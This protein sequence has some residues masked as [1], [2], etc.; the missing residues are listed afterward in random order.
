MPRLEKG[1]GMQIESER[2]RNNQTFASWFVR[3]LRESRATAIL[4]GVI[5]LGVVLSILSPVFLSAHNLQNIVVQSVYTA[6]IAVGMTFV[7][8]TAGID[9]SVGGIVFLTLVVATQISLTVKGPFGPYLVYMV[10]ILLGAVLGLCNG[11]I[12]NYLRIDPVITTLATLNIFRGLAIHISNAQILIPNQ[13]ARFL[14]VGQV[15]SFPVPI[16][17]LLIIAVLAALSLSYTKFGRYSLAIGS[18]RRSALESGLSV[19][20]ISVLVYVIGGFCAAIGGLILVGRVGAVQTDMGIG[21][22]FTVITAVVLGGTVLSGGKASIVGSI[23][24]AVFLVMIDN[25]LDLLNASVYIYDIVR[26]AVLVAAVV[27]DRVSTM[28]SLRPVRR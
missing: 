12:V 19:R 3:L 16:L 9:I 24:G 13:S 4:S 7:I 26:G 10:S 23:L 17:V 25:G 14:G 27:I 2:L 21:V 28:R 6:V 5:I 1:K 22:E 15:G 20:K 11:L 8:M 18:S